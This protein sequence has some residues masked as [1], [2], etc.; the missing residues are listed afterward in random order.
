VKEFAHGIA[1]RIRSRP[2][3]S[4][5]L[6]MGVGFVVG[7]ALSFRFGRALLASAS[8]HVAR[9]LLKQVL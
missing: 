9:E 7:G 8:R 6:A 1:D 5:A 2:L 3:A 4:L